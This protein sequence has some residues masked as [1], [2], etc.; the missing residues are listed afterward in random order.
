MPAP[1]QHRFIWAALGVLAFAAL[2]TPALLDYLHTP[3]V[4]QRHAV[5]VNRCALHAVQNGAEAS[6]ARRRCGDLLGA[7]Q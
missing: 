1:S 5:A 6:D 4:A 3:T 7:G 2:I